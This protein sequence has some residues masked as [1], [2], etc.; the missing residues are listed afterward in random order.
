MNGSED[1]PSNHLVMKKLQL[2]QRFGVAALLVL[3]CAIFQSASA[4]NIRK[5]E[6]VKAIERVMPAVVNIGTE[7]IVEVRD[8]FE[9]LLREFWGPYYR[10]RPQSTTYSLGS[11]VIFDEEGYVL[12]NEHVVRRATRIWVNLMDG[13]KL[14]A[15]RVAGDE[16]SD[17]ALLKIKAETGE[18]FQSIPFAHDDDLMLGE[19]VIA[20]GNPF[21]L[22]GSVSKGILS[23]KSRRQ[24]R[25]DE[26]LDV[27]DW[28]QTDAA[29]NPGNSGGPL[30]NLNGELIGLSVAVYREGQG[31]GFAIPIKR[32][33]EALGRFLSPEEFQAIWFGARIRPGEKNLVVHSV[34]GYSPADLA[35]LKA[36]DSIRK[37][38]GRTPA[39]FMDF[40][41][42]LLANGTN[43]PVRLEVLSGQKQRTVSVNL[44]P[45]KDFFN[46]RLVQ[47]KTGLSVQELTLDL[48]E[49]LG[50]RFYGGFVVVDVEPDGPGE[51]AGLKKYSVIQA[52]DGQRPS[53]LIEL[54]KALHGKNKGDKVRIDFTILVRRGVYYGFSEAASML[55]LRK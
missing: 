22:G 53:N 20:L 49:Q 6:T 36:G 48:A 9:N 51:K 46:E 4:E 8:P 28:L 3:G 10:R 19:T 21:G 29:I 23:S 37:I 50:F 43:R 26:P 44:I 33:T 30:I 47:T 16:T 35:G 15:V 39:S 54:A 1:L 55:T 14:E 40:S 25:E 32:V 34:Q 42:E 38:N 24:P 11:G 41:R 31:I 12:T 2:N 13:R 17:V 18:K 7:T 27:A 5:N 45:E 52:V